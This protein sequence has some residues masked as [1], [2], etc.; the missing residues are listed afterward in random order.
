MSPY[1]GQPTTRARRIIRTRWTTPTRLTIR[2]RLALL[3]ATVFFVGC[4]ALLA[5]VWTSAREIIGRNGATVMAVAAKPVNSAQ[6]EPAITAAPTEPA[7]GLGASSAARFAAF[8]QDVLE[9]LLGRCLLLLVVIGFLSLLASWWVAKRGL[10]RIGLVTAAARDIGDRNLHARLDLVGP[11]D[12]AKELA[13]TFD[14]MLDRLERSFAE[15]RRFTGHAS[16]ELRTPLTVQRAALEIPLAQGRIPDDLLPDVRRALNAT[17]RS[18][19][20]IAALLALAKGESGVL[21]PAAVDLA[22][23]ARTAIAEVLD[24]ARET[25]VTVDTRLSPA[26]VWGDPS[27][28]GQLVGNLVTNAVRHNERDGSVHIATGPTGGGGAFV[29]VTNTGARVDASDLPTLYEPFR[30]GSGRRK[31][32]GLGLSVVRAVTVTHQGTLT[33][34]ANPAGGLTVRVE[35]PAER[36]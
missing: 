31:G 35:L 12:E 32:A 3:N 7:A 19:R 28:L 34:E 4:A 18:E 13:D 2:T 29:E 11:A 21:V 1:L 33:T 30:R 14:A 10:S 36:A 24:E 22:E 27:L 17:H 25:E 23:E 8:E 20:L 5:L 26:P 15:Q 6:S 16:H 9:E